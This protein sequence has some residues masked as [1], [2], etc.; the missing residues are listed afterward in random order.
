MDATKVNKSA[1]FLL[2]TLTSA[3]AFAQVPDA[4]AG[5]RVFENW[6]AAC[7]AAG[8][9][10]PGTG[11]LQALYKGEKPAPL[12]QRLNLSPDF[13]AAF[14]RQG[15]SIMPFFRKT[16]VS[17]KDLLDLSTYLSPSAAKI[18]DNP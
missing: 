11:A 8:P 18:R 7:H 3:S 12:E 2:I 15:V 9:K 6:C 17:D 1:L 16:E 4:V 5:K 13:I 14:V 10:H